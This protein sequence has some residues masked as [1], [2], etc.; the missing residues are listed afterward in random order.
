MVSLPS[1]L[2]RWAHPPM[3]DCSAHVHPRNPKS[4]SLEGMRKDLSSSTLLAKASSMICRHLRLRVATVLGYHT[5]QRRV[6]MNVMSPEY[7]PSAVIWKTG[8]CELTQ[9]LS[10]RASTR[11]GKYPSHSVTI[12]RKSSAGQGYSDL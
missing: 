12:E 4:W 10:G 7:L 5:W 3:T 1:K 6:S 9:V 8:T 11:I 2:R